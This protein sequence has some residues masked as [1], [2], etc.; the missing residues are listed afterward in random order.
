MTS[1]QRFWPSVESLPTLAAVEA[2]WLAHLRCDYP[3]VKPFLRPRKDRASSFPRPDGGLPYQVIEHG[4]DVLVGVC[5]ETGET[6]TL[7]K[8]QL[9]VYELDEQRLADQ[10]ASALGLGAANKIVT[11][12]GRLFSLG[13]FRPTGHSMAVFLI[14]PSDSA[15]VAS[16]V[17]SLISQGVSPFLLLTPTRRFV[18]GELDLR[19]RSLG[20]ANLPLVET[21][22]V[23]GDGKWSITDGAIR[24]TL[25]DRPVE[26]ESLSDG[27]TVVIQ[28]IA[29]RRGG[30]PHEQLQIPRE[31]KGITDAVALGRLGNMFDFAQ[32]VYEASI[33]DVIAC[34]LY[35]PA[36]VHIVGH[37]K[38]R[39]LVL[40]RDRDL[41]VEMTPL[42]LGQ[43]ETLFS[44]FDP[45]VQLVVF[46]T[47]Q[48]LE[49]AQHLTGRG[50]VDIA[51]GVKGL[52]SD[53]HA[54]QFAKSFYR[55]LADGENVKR[56]FD[57]AGL[58]LG[59][60]DAAA[61][62]QLRAA[63]GVDP[64]LVVFGAKI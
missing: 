62:P 15:E 41:L 49:L 57:L 28:F 48:S 31:L 42:D 10:V 38:E 29:G 46:N 16:G 6:I 19:L 45:Q 9:V 22:V 24:A 54:V 3:L 17:A 11:Q 33:D 25:P 7:R 59:S 30:G 44:N 14:F 51:I 8:S 32:A 52:I 39:S 20:S 35:R 37:G 18:T 34:R 36:I 60:A 23:S 40:V 21:L 4:R 58:H 61:R 5:Q 63:A 50:V 1:L 56:A 13:S 12:E 55:L 27:A 64:A 43:A 47:C 2:E 53:D 26:D